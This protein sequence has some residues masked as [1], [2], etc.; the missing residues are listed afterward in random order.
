MDS[1]MLKSWRRTESLIYGTINCLTSMRVCEFNLEFE[2]PRSPSSYGYANAWSTEDELKRQVMKA[3]YA[4]KN[5]LAYLT[6]L[7][8]GSAFVTPGDGTAIYTPGGDVTWPRWANAA[9]RD[10]G[11]HPAWL[12]MLLRSDIANFECS[13]VGGFIRVDR[14][15]FL[16]YVRWMLPRRIPLVF[17]W[18][19]NDSSYGVK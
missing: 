17:V 7:I 16:S 9:V 13:R 11:V 14:C 3:R 8:T 2:M 1:D 15:T 12:Q 5:V 10:H 6:F 19:L 18:P 4:F